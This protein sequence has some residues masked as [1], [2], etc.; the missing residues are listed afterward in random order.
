MN[1]PLYHGSMMM[2]WT[3][4]NT[5]TI[6]PSAKYGYSELIVSL[7][8]KNEQLDKCREILTSKDY[9]IS[10]QKQAKKRSLS[11]NSYMWVICDK[12]AEVLG[13][14]KEEVYRRAVRQVGSYETIA[15]K[16]EAFERFKSI[17]EGRGIGWCIEVE[18]NYGHYIELQ[19]YKG[20]S[21][22]NRKEMSRL[23]KW[24]VQ[25]A[26]EQGIDVMTPA[27]RALLIDEWEGES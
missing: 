27:E 16:P 26:E 18:G 6:R 5:F 15:V 13:I 20:S 21:T 22:Y 7:H 24:L 14:S 23:I 10:L 25:E 12:L 17:W 8:T 2:K 9:Q 11:A 3:K 4:A 19:A 1:S